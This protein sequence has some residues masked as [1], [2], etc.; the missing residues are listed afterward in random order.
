MARKI[1]GVLSK[2]VTDV[3]IESDI[4]AAELLKNLFF[5]LRISRKSS[6]TGKPK[7][8]VP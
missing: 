8:S 6:S 3:Q 2:N 5:D 7:L 1:L 4:R